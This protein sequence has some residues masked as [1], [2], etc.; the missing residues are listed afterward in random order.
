[1]LAVSLLGSPWLVC[2]AAQTQS[3]GESRLD[4]TLHLDGVR[5]EAE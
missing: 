5:I 3:P 2:W 1:M 4:V